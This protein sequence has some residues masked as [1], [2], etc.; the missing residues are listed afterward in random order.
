MLED[1]DPAEETCDADEECAPGESRDCDEV[2]VGNIFDAMVRNA[3]D[4]RT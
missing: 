4:N 2:S 1:M 3:F